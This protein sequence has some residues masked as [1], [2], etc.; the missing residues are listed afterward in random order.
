M[1]NL[2]FGSPA[3]TVTPGLTRAK[4]ISAP[5]GH[6]EPTVQEQEMFSQ[7]QKLEDK[8]ESKLQEI[9][10]ILVKQPTEATPLPKKVPKR[11]TIEELKAEKREETAKNFLRKK[12][13]TVR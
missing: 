1:G 12:P 13:G 4:S 7:M 6:E 10:H 8:I 3:P 11:K 9:D 2:L 5:I